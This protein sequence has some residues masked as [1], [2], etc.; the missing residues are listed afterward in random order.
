MICDTIK[1]IRKISYLVLKTFFSWL[2]WIRNFQQ[3]PSLLRKNIPTSCLLSIKNQYTQ[4]EDIFCLLLSFLIMR[5]YFS[6][7]ITLSITKNVVLKESLRIVE[8][9]WFRSWMSLS[10]P[11]FKVRSCISHSR[12]SLHHSKYI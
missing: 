1:K 7:I 11:Y 6:L 2:Q 10:G 4:L 12:L 3:L 9:L 5:D 8:H